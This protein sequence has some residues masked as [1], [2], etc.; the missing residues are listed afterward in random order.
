VEIAAV[1]QD[2]KSLYFSGFLHK[3]HEARQRRRWVQIERQ[4]IDFSRKRR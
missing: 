4:A 1:V 3:N 2:Q